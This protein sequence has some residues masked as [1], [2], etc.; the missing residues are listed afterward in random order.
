MMVLFY[1]DVHDEDGA[2][3]SMVHDE[4]GAYLSMVHDEDGER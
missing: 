3:L 1:K 2:N 4:D